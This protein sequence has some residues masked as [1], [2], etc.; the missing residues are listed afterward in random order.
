[1]NKYDAVYQSCPVCAA[2]S[3]RQYHADFRGNRIFICPECTVQ[4]MNPVYSDNY[5][6][7]YYANYYSGRV[8]DAEVAEG[9]RRNNKMKFRFIDKF[10][11][12]PGKV[13]D[14]GCGNGNF[15][16]FSRERG[17][18]VLGYDVDCEA[19]KKVGSRYGIPIKCGPLPDVDWAGE[20]FKLIH[21]NHV[22]EHLKHPVRDLKILHKLLADDGYL[23][24]GVPN[25]HAWSARVKLL[26][27]KIGLKR[28]RVGKYYDSDH[29]VFYYTP[30]SMKVL[31]DICGFEVML[32]MN[33]DK[34]HLS[35]SRWV[36][37][38][39][40]DLPNYF[41]SNSAFFVIARKKT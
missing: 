14:F 21:A 40:Y 23:Y 35:E 12:A 3:I 6:S 11:H 10:A 29:H 4:F 37:I 19:M 18:D 24:I 28:S 32:M 25:I 20:R 31:L 2:G 5:L 33:S 1:M 30:R 9:Q 17:W 26:L 22:V 38:I 8:S 15:A 27:E 34:S 36:Q 7:E 39:M 41:Y 13:L 16:N